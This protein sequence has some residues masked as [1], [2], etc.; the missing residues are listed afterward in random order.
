MKTKNLF[1]GRKKFV[2]IPVAALLGLF[3]LPV[4][5]GILLIYFS[6]KKIRLK[7]LRYSIVGILSL[8]TLFF[9]TAY[10]AAFVSPSTPKQETK[11]PEAVISTS[12]TPILAMQNQ[13]L[14]KVTRV[15]D[16]DTIEIE[17]GQRVRLIG[18]DTPETVDPNRPAGCYGTDASSFTKAQLEGKEIKLEKDISETDQYGRLLRY[19]WLGDTLFNETLVKEGYAQVSTYPP[20]V[21]NSERFLAAQ[22]EARDNNR[23]LWST[24]QNTPAPSTS[25]STPKPVTATPKPNVATQQTQTSG[26]CKYSCNSPD[27]DCSDFSTHAEAQA[28]F[29]CCGFSA[30]NDPMRLDKATGTGNGIACES[31]P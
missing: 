8:I 31:L 30:G 7:P 22:K 21:K 12:P 4:T 24:C 10:V 6:N 9:G 29:N 23:G 13:G 25:V 27:R 17:G 3:F 5:I 20:D 2:T 14:V 19:V 15:I 26:S 11:E 1:S 18:I 16:G 28:F